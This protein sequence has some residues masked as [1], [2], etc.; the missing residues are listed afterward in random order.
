ML[1]NR[2][3]VCANRGVCEPERPEDAIGPGRFRRLS[4]NPAGG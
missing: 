2:S 4:E 1:A 3:D